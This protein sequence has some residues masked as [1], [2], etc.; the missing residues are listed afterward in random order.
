MSRKQNTWSF[1]NADQLTSFIGAGSI[2][3]V[4]GD[5]AI[6]E[7]TGQR[8]VYRAPPV[9]AWEPIDRPQAIATVD[10]VTTAIDFA[11]GRNVH[12]DISAQA[13]AADFT[14]SNAVAGITYVL[15]FA[16]GPGVGIGSTWPANVL[17]PGGSAP[18][19]DPTALIRLY[20]DGT[21]F[22]GVG[23]SNFL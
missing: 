4:H 10:S 19:I 2:G 17:W 15:R 20:Y 21:N 18:A 13:S 23:D 1:A 12:L 16:N 6:L 22:Y 5:F 7:D 11:N 9:N 3:A 8:Y 14:L